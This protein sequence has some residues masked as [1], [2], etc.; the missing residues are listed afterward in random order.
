MSRKVWRG[1][2]GW[3]ERPELTSGGGAKVVAVV[4]V[5]QLDV[6]ML[7]ETRGPVQVGQVLTWTAWLSPRQGSCVFGPSAAFLPPGTSVFCL[8]IYW[9]CR[10][11]LKLLWYTPQG[12]CG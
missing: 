7:R 1:P 12:L 2:L 10:C 4:G 6:W 9:L 3:V 8:F 11:L 5:A